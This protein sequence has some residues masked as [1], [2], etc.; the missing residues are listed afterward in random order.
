MPPELPDPDKH[1]HR[2]P[3]RGEV[4]QRH[5]QDQV[6]RR[7]QRPHDQREQHADD[8]DRDRDHVR[9]VAVGDLA[10]VV[11]RRRLAAD[12]AG[13]RVQGRADRGRLGPQGRNRVQRGRAAR[14]ARRQPGLELDGGARRVHVL[15][16]RAVLLVSARPLGSGDLAR[17]G[18]RDGRRGGRQLAG[19]EHRVQRRVLSGCEAGAPDRVQRAGHAGE[20]RTVLKLGGGGRD[21]RRVLPDRR[22]QL[23]DQVGRVRRRGREVLGQQ[24]LPGCRVGAGRGRDRAAEAAALI[25]G[26]RHRECAEDDH[27]GQQRDRRA[28]QDPRRDHAP[29]AGRGRARLGLRRPERG[30]AEDREQRRQ[31]R[32]PG[33]S[34][35]PM[36]MASGMPR[37]E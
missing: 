30:L 35:T 18:G 28:L 4:G 11:E 8:H 15:R 37:S 5:R 32:E 9:Q 26:D 33:N 20:Q 6:D 25:R 34:I 31:Q 36:P 24:V 3:E 13:G 19:A 29:G 21:D 23:V 17:Q 10:D 27:A 1:D 14:I 7:D 2:E 12:A 22:R 16:G